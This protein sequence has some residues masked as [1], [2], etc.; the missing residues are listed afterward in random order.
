MIYQPGD[1]GDGVTRSRGGYQV[2]IKLEPGTFRA[3]GAP[4]YYL[5]RPASVW[6][7]ALN[8]RH[9]RSAP[10]APGGSRSHGQPPPPGRAGSR[11]ARSGRHLASA[12]A[13]Q[14]A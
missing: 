12:G 9:P 8:P 14:R 10:Q 7:A 5:G 4:A 6:I 2:L 11:T 3:N 1:R 13:K